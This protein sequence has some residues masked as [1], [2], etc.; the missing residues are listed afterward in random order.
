MNEKLFTQSQLSE[1]DAGKQNGVQTWIYAKP[2]LLAIQMRQIRL[3]LEAGLP[4]NKYAI[5]AYDWFQMEE[6]R[7]GL[8]AGVDVSKYDK[9]DIPFDSMR[10][11]RLGLEEGYDLTAGIRFQPGILKEFRLS[12]NAH[13][14]ITSYIKQG[15]SEEQ[16]R[17]IRL[18]LEN[19]I[20]IA[21]FVT[22]TKRGYAIHEIALGLEKG[23]DVSLYAHDDYSW[24]QMREIRL[25]MEKRLDTTCYRKALYSWRQ[26]QE[27]RLGLE[28]HLD[29]S[30]YATLMHT[31]KEM[32]KKRLALMAKQGDFS[33]ENSVES[34]KQAFEN[35]TL[36]ISDDWMEANILWTGSRLLSDSMN[37]R[38]ALEQKGIVFGID[39]EALNLINHPDFA[40]SVLTVARGKMPEPGKDG[41]Y[42]FFFDTDVKSKPTILENGNVDYQSV[43]WFETAKKGQTVALYHEAQRGEDGCNIRGVHIRGTLGKEL[44]IMEG[45]GVS[46]LPDQKTYVASSDGKISLQD[47][48]LVI[49]EMLLLDDVTKL[50]GVITFDGPIH[51]RGTVSNGAEIHAGG[52]IL[53]DGFTESAKLYSDGDII[54]REGNNPGGK[55]EIHAKGDVMG[56]FFENALVESGNDIK[57]NYCLKSDLKAGNSV[58]IN[59]TLG[60]IVGG[61]VEAGKKISVANAGNQ[62][63]L[64]TVLKVGTVDTLQS[65]KTRLH[66]QEKSVQNEL[67][68]LKNAYKEFQRKYPPEVRN[69]NATY[70]KIESAIYTKEKEQNEITKELKRIEESQHANRASVSVRGT[71]YR[72]VYIEIDGIGWRADT[73]KNVLMKKKNAQIALSRNY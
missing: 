65:E 64:S 73:M 6:I 4:M 29:V 70:I 8:K 32:H 14:D 15:Y 62:N 56:A 39:E 12:L 5:P 63:G 52:D 19:N 50:N 1:I 23:L 37:I 49:T 48:Q 33:D 28:D 22:P 30:S 54:L 43:K 45:K 61:T 57:A 2:E 58:S 34:Q 40:D 68:L 31:A 69:V 47:E 24:Q 38:N 46:L 71:L 9:T 53:V 36:I 17:Q 3:G 7:L 13:V 25:G 66:A 18:A 59:G 27:I 10:Q 72:G 60:M 51:V 11:I 42:E 41:Y 16:L 20:V 67:H 26:M 55:G 44:P 21:P 35:F